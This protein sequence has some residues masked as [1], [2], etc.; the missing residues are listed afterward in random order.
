MSKSRLART[1]AKFETLPAWLRL[2]ALNFA[3]RKTIPFVGTAK[4]EVQALTEARSEFRL[5]NRRRVQN[6]IGGVHAAATALLA[7]TATGLVVGMNLPD[8]RIPLIKTLQVDYLKRAVGNLTAVA[9]LGEA[10]RRLIEE[11]EKG[12]VLV[13]VTITDSE[14][15]ETVACR[16]I[17]AWIPKKPR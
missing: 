4:L 12:E 14:G 2:R 16:M 9:T 6:H 8:D 3:L 13:P 1:V 10:D 15:T 7:E 11:T 17:W 5:R